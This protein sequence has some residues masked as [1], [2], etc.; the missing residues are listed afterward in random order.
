MKFFQILLLVTCSGRLESLPSSAAS[1]VKFNRQFKNTFLYTPNNLLTPFSRTSAVNGFDSSA[2]P[3]GV[4]LPRDT[5]QR[6]LEEEELPDDDY[7]GTADFR[8]GNHFP[9]SWILSM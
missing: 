4:I 2:A 5:S 9:R 6:S 8:R 7:E 1:F 3:T